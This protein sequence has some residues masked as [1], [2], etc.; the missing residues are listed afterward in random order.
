MFVLLVDIATCFLLILESL[1]RALDSAH[2]SG[3]CG[4]P[5]TG[6]PFQRSPRRLADDTT[7]PSYFT[8]EKD[9]ERWVE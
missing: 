8:Q 4:D 7:G 1:G 3:L 9:R 2:H 6:R 5:H